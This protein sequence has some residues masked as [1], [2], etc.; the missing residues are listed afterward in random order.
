MQQQQRL[1]K[2]RRLVIFFI[3][4]LALSGITAFP[5]YTELTF[6]KQQGWMN[7][8]WFFGPW[9]DKVY[10]GVADTYS[11]YPFLFYGYDWLAFAHIMVAALFYGV[12][13]DP[14]RNKFILNWGMF[15]CVCIVPLAFICGTI[16]GIPIYHILIDCSF[17][18]IGIIPL[19]VCKR[20]ILQ[21]EQVR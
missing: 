11:K 10:N 19:L 14:I 21:L 5:V 17:G 8:D 12:Y 6:L 9:L 15:C 18:V 4:A 1:K 7:D 13:K 2:I 20:Y 3:I 16:R